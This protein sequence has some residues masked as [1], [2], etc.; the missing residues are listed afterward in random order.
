MTLDVRALECRASRVVGPARSTRRLVQ[1]SR[2]TTS[3]GCGRRWDCSG[4]F[5]VGDEVKAYHEVDLPPVAK[6]AYECPIAR[7]AL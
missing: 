3:W 1:P 2:P 5:P 4:P 6:R 7:K